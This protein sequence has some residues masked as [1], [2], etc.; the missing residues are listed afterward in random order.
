[1]DIDCRGSNLFDEYAAAVDARR[2]KA[3]E[4]LGIPQDFKYTKLYG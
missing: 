3:Y 1:M 4:Q 2:E